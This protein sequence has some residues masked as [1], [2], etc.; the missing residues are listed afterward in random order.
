MVRVNIEKV[1]EAKGITK[2]YMGSRVGL[3]CTGYRHIAVGSVKLTVDRF[4][5]FAK[6]LDCPPEVLLSDERTECF[7]QENIYKG[8]PSCLDTV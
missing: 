2:T 6:V 3:T 4:L 8:E 7:I 5:D 1:R